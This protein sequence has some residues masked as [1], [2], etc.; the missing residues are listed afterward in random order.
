MCGLDKGF[1]V[2]HICFSF[3][4]SMESSLLLMRPCH[5]AAITLPKD[6]G[7]TSRTRRREVRFWQFIWIYSLS[8]T[9]ISSGIVPVKRKQI[10]KTTYSEHCKSQSKMFNMMTLF[11]FLQ[12]KLSPSLRRKRNQVH[13]FRGTVL[14][15]SFWTSGP[16][17]HQHSTR[18]MLHWL[19]TVINVKSSQSFSLKCPICECDWI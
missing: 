13:C 10:L 14:T 2:N 15:H 3:P 5:I 9:L 19:I 11:I 8:G 12:K 17:F 7:G 1:I 6:T 16:S 4:L 18:S